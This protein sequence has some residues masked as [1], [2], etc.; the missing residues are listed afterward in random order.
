MAH[1]TL[2]TEQAVSAPRLNYL[3]NMSSFSLCI[4]ADFYDH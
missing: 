1:W 4:W 2:N 3:R